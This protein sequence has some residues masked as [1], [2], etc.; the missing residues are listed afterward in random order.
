MNTDIKDN[1]DTPL[2]NAAIIYPPGEYYHDKVL[3][4]DCRKIERMYNALQDE[5]V[6]ANGLL[7][8]RMKEIAKLKQTLIEVTTELTAIKCNKIT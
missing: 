5:I 2:S 7:D 8:M 4:D 6:K 1:S 3:V